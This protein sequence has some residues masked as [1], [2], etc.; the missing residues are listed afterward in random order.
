MI[1]PEKIQE[2]EIDLTSSSLL[3]TTGSDRVLASKVS[4]RKKKEHAVSSTNNL[5][6]GVSVWEE[7]NIQIRTMLSVSENKNWS[8]P[9]SEELLLEGIRVTDH[10]TFFLG[11]MDARHAEFKE[12]NP[13]ETDRNKFAYAMQILRMN[14][15]AKVERV[16]GVLRN[17]QYNIERGENPIYTQ[18]HSALTVEKY[19]TMVWPNDYRKS[20]EFRDGVVKQL[21]ED[22]HNL[23]RFFANSYNTSS[24]L[25]KAEK[26]FRNVE[27][28]TELYEAP[29][30]LMR[31]LLLEELM[32]VHN[33]RFINNKFSPRNGPAVGHESNEGERAKS[34]LAYCCI[35]DNLCFS[36]LPRGVAKA[37]KFGIGDEVKDLVENF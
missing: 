30:S 35:L 27:M 14:A 4:E 15:I 20:T 17:M 34:F 3:W 31:K 22:F 18:K 25:D 1:S 36:R 11:I 37:T 9:S 5:Y 21:L 12:C 32:G 29:T 10:L 23:E 24:P 19:M 2:S 26:I 28:R 7:M 13:A 16:Q 6:S 33:L 8:V